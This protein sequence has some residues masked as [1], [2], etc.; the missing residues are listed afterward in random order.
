MTSYNTEV[1]AGYI[2]MQQFD[3]PELQKQS[4]TDVWNRFF[5]CRNISNKYV[6]CEHNK[7]ITP[8]EGHSNRTKKKHVHH[9][10][11]KP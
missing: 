2:N 6:A 4:L 8:R 1:L 3:C 11:L 7:R 5:S 9:F 10:F